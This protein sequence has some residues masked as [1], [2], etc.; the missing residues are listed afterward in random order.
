M[1]ENEKPK[2]SR[3]AA[4]KAASSSGS[5]KSTAIRSETVPTAQYSS[6]TGF[7]AGQRAPSTK[8]VTEDGEVVDDEP[9]GI[10]TVLVAE[11]DVVRE[12]M[13]DAI[14]NGSTATRLRF[15]NEH[16]PGD[17]SHNE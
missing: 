6:G 4:K 3:R 8:Y 1:A 17:A 15:D 11:G 16:S 5:N 10:S 2:P 12:H 14:K 13:V 9:T 7:E